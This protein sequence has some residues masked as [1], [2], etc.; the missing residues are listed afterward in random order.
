[1][2]VTARESY[3]RGEKTSIMHCNRMISFMK[4]KSSFFLS[5][6][7]L[8][9]FFLSFTSES[10]FDFL[11]QVEHT[12][13]ASTNDFFVDKEAKVETNFA[14]TLFPLLPCVVHFVS[15]TLF[16]DTNYFREDTLG[17]K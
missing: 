3:K 15:Y 5:H 4:I 7:T 9:A 17:N 11:T 1:M 14:L 10:W 8:K 6:L 13:A 16:H 12:H 2:T